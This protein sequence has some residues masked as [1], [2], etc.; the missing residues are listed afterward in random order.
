MSRIV[1]SFSSK[2]ARSAVVA[3]IVS[4]LS[5]VALTAGVSITPSIAVAQSSDAK[6]KQNQDELNKIRKERQELER[7]MRTLEINSKNISE[8]LDNISK[9]HNATQRAVKSLDKQLGDITDAVKETS[10][11]LNQTQQEAVEKRGVLNRRLVDIYKRGP[12]FDLE[13]LMSSRSLGALLARYKYLHELA[14]SDRALAQRLEALRDTIAARKVKLVGLQSNLA[15]N[16]NEKVKEESRLKTLERRQQ[17]DLK[18]VQA[19]AKKAKNRLRQLAQAEARLNN[20]I[21][22]LEA[23]RKKATTG[24]AAPKTSSSIK[25]TDIGKLDWPV[26]GSILYN[27]GVTH[28]PNGTRILW[29][30]IGIEADIGTPV[31]S[32]SSGTVRVA[33]QMGAYG[34][35]II[36]EHGG[37]DYSIYGS[38]SEMR[39]KEGSKVT[40]GMIIGTVGRADPDQPPHLHF[41]IRRGEGKAVDPTTWL[42][43]R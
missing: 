36:I 9:Q 16:K 25:T 37:G 30:G 20:L 10:A 34:K 13:V 38:L 11:S 5:T 29:N 15:Q 14:V 19:D 42:R 32:V 31:K 21:A 27:F 41:E 43:G 28:T 33:E 26:N 3:V 18:K 4:T 6:I 7:R 24:G 22:R 12:L 23:E 8:K 35:T 40:K 2:G 1:E 17:T 39:V